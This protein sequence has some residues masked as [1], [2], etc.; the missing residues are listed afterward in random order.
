MKTIQLLVCLLA[1][2][3]SNSN[4]QNCGNWADLNIPNS[5]LH[6]TTGCEANG[7][8]FAVNSKFLFSSTDNATTWN[9]CTFS[10]N[11]NFDGGIWNNIQVLYS[12]ANNTYY[13]FDHY[14]PICYSTNNGLYWD[15]PTSSSQMTFYAT[16]ISLYND[17][18]FL[19]QNNGSKNRISVYDFP[20]YFTANIDTVYNFKPFT[21]VGNYYFVY[22]YNGFAFNLYRSTGNP[23]NLI[24]ITSNIPVTI[25]TGA[26]TAVGDTLY[27][28]DNSQVNVYQS[29]DYGNTWNLFA[30][31]SG[32]WNTGAVI[33]GYN[34][35]NIYAFIIDLGGNY[36]SMKYSNN[37][38]TSWIPIA[39]N[40]NSTNP[41]I[42]TTQS[43]LYASM[44]RF[45][46]T[47]ITAIDSTI[48]NYNIEHISTLNNYQN[49]ILYTS[50]V[51][52][53]YSEHGFLSVDSGLNFSDISNVCLPGTFGGGIV[54][55]QRIFLSSLGN[56]SK[57]SN[58]NGTTWIPA[59]PQALFLNHGDTVYGYW[60]TIQPN[61][62]YRSFDGGVT[63][64]SIACST[65]LQLSS[66]V[67][68]G[69]HGIYFK[70]SPIYPND[71]LFYLDDSSNSVISITPAIPNGSYIGQ[72]YE[73]NNKALA[74]VYDTVANIASLQ[75]ST[76]HYA[77]L[78]NTNLSF[79]SIS[80]F[81]PRRNI[82]VVNTSQGY[83]SSSDMINWNPYTNFLGDTCIDD[84]LEKNQNT[85]FGTKYTTFPNSI[86][87]TELR[88]QT[89]SAGC[90][91]QF[92]L[93]PDTLPHHYFA[94]NQSTGSVNLNYAWN[95]G[96]G[97]AITTGATPS[98]TFANAG[99]YNICLYIND[100]GG[101][102]SSFCDSST[103]TKSMANTIISVDVVSQLPSYLSG[104][105]EASNSK[106]EVIF[107][108]NP[109]KDKLY[110]TGNSKISSIKMYDL[111]GNEMQVQT[112]K[113]RAQTNGAFNL[114][115]STLHL[116]SGIY[117]VKVTDANGV[118]E[119]R[120]VVK[121]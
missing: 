1:I 95:W 50:G 104:L 57:Q 77:T 55:S 13:L 108:P 79:T 25:A 21:K 7:V 17:S 42:F 6:F 62:I 49:K 114:E 110:I 82:L 107:Y 115:L 35:N 37:N 119:V 76:N 80:D 12:S 89:Y 46:D 54:T 75:Y 116:K 65:S 83:Y 112:N 19:G 47:N 74:I 41:E 78:T 53:F 59:N 16:D 4:A 39:F 22:Q 30:N 70:P 60:S 5:T 10:A 32:S 45:S 120:K 11:V 64:D 23:Y 81:I 73:F 113:S 97:S 111:V 99:F 67:R 48:L 14:H 71:S 102:S 92:T 93:I 18:L 118:T 117:F 56:Y 58:D 28:V 52:I 105:N 101:C 86:K 38:G 66:N 43:N 34:S 27:I 9:E 91:A 85:E 94:L 121:E 106:E 3:F 15:V 68:I 90:S 61:M 31:F 96:D 109:T 51:E 26:F 20:N 29:V 87:K 2:S 36:S 63:F 88:R 98:H 44:H 100:G 72:T 84:W 33:Y 103:I 24:N 69:S 8:L 40:T